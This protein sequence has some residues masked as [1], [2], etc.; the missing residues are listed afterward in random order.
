MKFRY[1]VAAV[2]LAFTGATTSQAQMVES[3]ENISGQIFLGALGG[4][5]G[6][7]TA[8]SVANRFATIAENTESISGN[9]TID[10]TGPTSGEF[11]T[12]GTTVAGALNQSVIDLGENA[13]PVGAIVDA[14]SIAGS[15][16][17]MTGALN[18]AEIAGN[19]GL[20]SGADL[21][22]VG[23]ISTTVVGALNSSGITV[24]F[25]GP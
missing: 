5:N 13:I 11:A 24:K 19:I 4:A 21:G 12:I 6:N 25:T 15:L 2:A 18:T 3:F 20:T 22:G 1:F 23:A 17:A 7:S 14:T 10:L 9:V 8:G 16:G